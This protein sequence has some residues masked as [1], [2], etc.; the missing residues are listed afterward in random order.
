VS[1]GRGPG[2]VRDDYGFGIFSPA[3]PE[4]YRGFERI[5]GRRL[6][7]SR[8]SAAAPG[9]QSRQY[10]LLARRLRTLLPITRRDLGTIGAPESLARRRRPRAGLAVS[11][12]DASLRLRPALRP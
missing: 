4:D 9:R 6:R 3:L 5:H 2:R 11:G 1:S 10:R 12:N 7:L 8:R